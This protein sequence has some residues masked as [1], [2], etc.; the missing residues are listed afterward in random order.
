MSVEYCAYPFLKEKSHLCDYEI[1]TD[2]LASIHTIRGKTP[3]PSYSAGG[4]PSTDGNDLS[5]QWIHPG[6]VCHR[7][8]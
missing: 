8:G 5:R 7:G 4:P 6:S 1:A 3:H 2:R